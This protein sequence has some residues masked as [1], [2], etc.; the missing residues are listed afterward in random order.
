MLTLILDK[1]FLNL[2]ST[3]NLKTYHLV[4]LTPTLIS[5]KYFRKVFKFN[6]LT[7]SYSGCTFQYGNFPNIQNEATNYPIN[8]GA[9]SLT[10]VNGV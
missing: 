8:I 6:G 3:W 1:L 10:T 7:P 2:R 5:Y 9:E 4:Q